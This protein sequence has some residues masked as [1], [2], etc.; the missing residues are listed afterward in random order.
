MFVGIGTWSER[1]PELK[2]R[3][4]TFT[5]RLQSRGWR[6]LRAGSGSTLA[7]GTRVP[8]ELHAL[9]VLVPSHT[10]SSDPG[11]RVALGSNRGSGHTAHHRQLADM[12]QCVGDRTL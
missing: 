6:S 8:V 10:S 3:L 9:A 4:H 12:R 2:F 11:T 1:P 5:K 7:L